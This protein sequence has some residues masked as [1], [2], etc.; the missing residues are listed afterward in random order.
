MVRKKQTFINNDAMNDRPPSE[1]MMEEIVSY[2]KG[3]QMSA[4][5]M[6]TFL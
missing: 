5:M 1:E 6:L 2:Y 4:M 3:T